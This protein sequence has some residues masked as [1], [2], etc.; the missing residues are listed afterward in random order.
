L[1]DNLSRDDKDAILLAIW[2]L[3]REDR[4]ERDRAD[5]GAAGEQ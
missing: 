2:T 1:S 4:L 3:R 5:Q